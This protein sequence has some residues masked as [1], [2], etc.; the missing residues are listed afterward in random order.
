ML[1]DVARAPG[2]LSLVRSP[3]TSTDV[4]G[5]GLPGFDFENFENFENLEPIHY[6]EETKEHD[7]QEY[8]AQ[9]REALAKGGKLLYL[10]S[11]AWRHIEFENGAPF[12]PIKHDGQRGSWS[13]VLVTE[14]D[15]KSKKPKPQ[16][17]D[18]Y[19]DKLTD[20]AKRQ[21]DHACR[22]QAQLRRGFRTFLTLTFN[23]EAR[24]QLQAFDEMPQGTKGRESIGSYA[25][26]FFNAL[27]NAWQRGKGF[28]SHWLQDGKQRTGGSYQAKH[29]RVDAW[30]KSAKWC[31]LKEEMGEAFH[32][33]GRKEL[34][35]NFI[36]VAEN[37][38]T[39]KHTDFGPVK[40]ENPHIH[41]L[42]NWHVKNKQ[43]PA[44]ARWI[45]SVWGKGFANLQK[46]KK[47]AAAAAYMGKAANYISKGGDGNQGRIRGN[48][49]SVSKWARAPRAR[50]KMYQAS[51]FKDALELLQSQDK[52]KLPRGLWVS[53]YAIGSTDR[54]AWENLWRLLKADGFKLERGTTLAAANFKYKSKILEYGRDCKGIGY[55][56]FEEHKILVS[57]LNYGAYPPELSL[58]ELQANYFH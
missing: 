9:E 33:R 46:L 3:E 1:N 29:G 12:T 11:Q 44:W 14:A 57:G 31:A 5:G 25:R 40:V 35:F 21:I 20:N 18:R 38:A 30:N 50:V 13:A 55:R 58:E 16:Y 4:P 22:Y 6:L 23:Q 39:V 32:I 8:L 53:K 47:P 24:D 17:G 26:K 56:K 48:R 51:W 36:W 52:T 7:W 41:V 43:F 2:A 54:K 37:P 34:P 10:Q 42:M 49:F 15:S 19:T 45:E 27:N 28:R